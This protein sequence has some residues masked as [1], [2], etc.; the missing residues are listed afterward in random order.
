MYGVRV[1]VGQGD[2]VLNE[3]AIHPHV[4]SDSDQA[5]QSLQQQYEQLKKQY[6][7]WQEQLQHNQ[8]ILSHATRTV[9]ISKP[10]DTRSSKP[11]TNVRNVSNVVN[12]GVTVKRAESDASSLRYNDALN[13]KSERVTRQYSLRDEKPGMDS[14]N[15][16]NLLPRRSI[17]AERLRTQ[18]NMK[19]GHREQLTLQNVLKGDDLLAQKSRLKRTSSSDTENL[20]PNSSFSI[21]P[22]SVE[23]VDST[24]QENSSVNGRP[25]LVLGLRKTPERMDNHE[26]ENHVIA[27]PKSILRKTSPT[28]IEKPSNDKLMDTIIANNKDTFLNT[29]TH[30]QVRS[31]VPL[32]SGPKP[33]TAPKPFLKSQSG[34]RSVSPPS[35]VQGGYASGVRSVSPP[36]PPALPIT[37]IIKSSQVW[38]CLIKG[39]LLTQ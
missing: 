3:T 29:S 13:N 28:V 30:T 11:V 36:T 7:R 5:K 23:S 21:S 39:Q 33:Y 6:A 24:E 1:G 15:N 35:V 25:K 12:N 8:A 26:P 18:D 10:V 22:R 4:L 2:L 14:N 9:N 38:Q 20:S 31:N 32:R 34:V 19:D 16:S 17:L 37:G 27:E